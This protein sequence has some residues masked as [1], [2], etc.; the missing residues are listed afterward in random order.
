M[1][2]KVAD[3]LGMNST[4]R[5]E[6]QV[7]LNQKKLILWKQLLQGEKPFFVSLLNFSPMIRDTEIEALQLEISKLVFGREEM[8]RERLELEIRY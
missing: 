6:Q 7:W 5:E 2:R 8:A 4:P 3:E 1:Q